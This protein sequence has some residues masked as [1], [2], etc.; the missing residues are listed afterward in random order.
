MNGP[1]R[2]FGSL[3]AAMWT[4]GALTNDR[5]SRRWE[6]ATCIAATAGGTSSEYAGHPSRRGSAATLCFR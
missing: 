5:I 6:F 3:R 4:W 2:I 1:P